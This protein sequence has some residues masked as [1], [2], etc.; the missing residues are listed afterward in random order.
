MKNIIFDLGGVLI[1]WDPDTVYKKYFGDD[2]EKMDRFYKEIQI[3]KV[4]AKLDR[5]L[6]FDEGLTEL[7]KKFP[8]YHEPIHL[9]KSKWIEMIGGTIDGSIKILESLHAQGYPLYALTNWATETFFTYIR[10]NYAFLNLFKDIVISGVEH[11]IKPEPE[12]Y[13]ILLRRNKLDPK[14]CIFI[15]DKQEN[16][17]PA[18]NLGMATIKFASPKQLQDELKLLGISVDI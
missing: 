7:A 15:D 18:K 16:L 13:K 12:I 2:L 9:W 4:N 6:P 17:I 1:A 8:K 10:Y 14:D 5:G 11:E 3:D